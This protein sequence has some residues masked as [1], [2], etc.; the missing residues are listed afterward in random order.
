MLVSRGLLPVLETMKASS[1]YGLVVIKLDSQ[2]IYTSHVPL[3]FN[4]LSKE[5]NDGYWLFNGKALLYYG[6][7]SCDGPLAL[8][9]RSVCCKNRR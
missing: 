4:L 1:A 7:F 9:G 3:T 6:E 8:A 2:S 5:H